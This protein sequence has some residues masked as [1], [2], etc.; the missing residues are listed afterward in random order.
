VPGGIGKPVRLDQIRLNC[1]RDVTVSSTADSGP[2]SLRKALGS[3]CMVETV[4]FSPALA[5]QTITLLSGPLT[6]GKNV[7]IDGSAAPGLTISGNN[8]DRV[9][10]INAGTTATVTSHHRRWLG[11]ARRRH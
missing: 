11:G 1:P 3:M 5:G 9:F 2:G 10:I 7:T 4:H 8:T 6:L